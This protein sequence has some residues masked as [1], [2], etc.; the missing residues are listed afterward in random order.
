VEASAAAEPEASKAASSSLDRALD[1]AEVLRQH[2]RRERRK[3][4]SPV[5]PSAATEEKRRELAE[6]LF[7]K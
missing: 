2:T 1:V 6:K 5:H 4:L 3:K 7:A